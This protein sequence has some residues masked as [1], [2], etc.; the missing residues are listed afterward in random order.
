MME[1]GDLEIPPKYDQPEYRVGWFWG[2]MRVIC[3][4]RITSDSFFARFDT[5]I[6]GKQRNV[7]FDS[8]DIGGFS[9]DKAPVNAREFGWFCMVLAL[10]AF[11]GGAAFE[12]K[13][14]WT[15][16]IDLKGEQ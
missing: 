13:A 6:D 15:Q 1:I 9:R 11:N 10:R 3:E 4:Y 7:C 8:S 2:D 16:K 5:Y 14:A 12:G